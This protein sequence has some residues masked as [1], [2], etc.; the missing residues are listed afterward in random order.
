[1][2]SPKPRSR[3]NQCYFGLDVMMKEKQTPLRLYSAA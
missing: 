1:M 2:D 3:R